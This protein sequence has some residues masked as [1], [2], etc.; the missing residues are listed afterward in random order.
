M[1][2][3]EKEKKLKEELND[4]QKNIFN[5]IRHIAVLFD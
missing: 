4:D 3:D 5:A 2:R 1:K